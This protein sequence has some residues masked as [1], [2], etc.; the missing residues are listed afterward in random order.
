[1]PIAWS[2]LGSLSTP[3]RYTVGNLMRRLNSLKRNPWSDIG[4]VKQRLPELRTGKKAR[5]A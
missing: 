4:R 1:M 3:N 2:E 5:G